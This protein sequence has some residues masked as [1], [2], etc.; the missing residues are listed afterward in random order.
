MTACAD[1]SAVPLTV[2]VQEAPFDAGMEIQALISG[3]SEAGALGS[4][5][6][7][8]RGGDDL[9]ALTLEHYPGMC[10]QVLTSLAHE[11]VERFSLC[12]CTLIHRVGRLTVGQPIVLVLTL[13]PHRADALDATRFL[14]DRLKTGAPFWKAEEFEDGRKQWV[15]SRAADEEAAAGW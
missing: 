4:F 13:A 6:G 7:L 5:L 12:G 3:A 10:E 2:R 14:I 1:I 15:E 8:V 11:A 9:T